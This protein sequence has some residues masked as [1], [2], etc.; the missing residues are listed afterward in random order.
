ME[1]Q[2]EDRSRR[3]RSSGS[4]APYAYPHMVRALAS[5]NLSFHYL[6][7]YDSQTRR[8][9]PTRTNETHDSRRI[10]R[11]VSSKQRVAFRLFL[12]ATAKRDG[13]SCASH[14]LVHVYVAVLQ[15]KLETG[16]NSHYRYMKH[17]SHP[18]QVS[19]CKSHHRRCWTSDC[20]MAVQPLFEIAISLPLALILARL[21]IM[22]G[23]NI[24]RIHANPLRVQCAM[25][26]HSMPNRTRLP[27]NTETNAR[28]QSAFIAFCFD[29]ASPS[30]PALQRLP[31]SHPR[32]LLRLSLPYQRRTPPTFTRTVGAEIPIH[33]TPDT[34]ATRDRHLIV[35]HPR[36]QKCWWRL[37]SDHA[38][39]ARN[40]C[41][42]LQAGGY[43]SSSLIKISA[44]TRI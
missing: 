7:S 32:P 38:R 36:R 17:S 4:S 19:I 5:H 22:G 12:R 41:A 6:R 20:M 16:T 37:H 26:F 13:R 11:T 34:Q 44:L 29:P 8:R 31:T 14:V 43:T 39:A 3:A 23:L 27:S 25:V 18:A 21:R 24:D 10:A 28:K 33:Q 9:T 35:A 40:V 30:P 1:D 42:T 15:M 2:L